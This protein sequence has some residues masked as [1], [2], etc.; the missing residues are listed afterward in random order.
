MDEGIE[1]ID[2]PLIEAVELSSPFRLELSIGLDRAEKAC[3]EG[4]I[5]A[6]EQLQEHE[7]DR[8]AMWQHLIPAR[9][10]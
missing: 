2:D 3:R 5:N 6:F 1:V 10:R 7:A 4:C 9:V 8:V